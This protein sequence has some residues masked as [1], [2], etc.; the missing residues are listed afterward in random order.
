[1][2]GLIPALVLE[3][4]EKHIAPLKLHEFFD[5]IVG[6]STGGMIAIG[7]SKGLQ[8]GGTT[9]DGSSTFVELYGS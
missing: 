7:I 5:L 6:T 1:M 3:E 8:A 2:R 9:Q 4:I